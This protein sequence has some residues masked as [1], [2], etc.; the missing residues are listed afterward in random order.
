MIIYMYISFNWCRFVWNDNYSKQEQVGNI[1][2]I[3][4][5]FGHY[6]SRN[7]ILLILLKY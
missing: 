7:V 6:N 5:F 2:I 3:C 1:N 4:T